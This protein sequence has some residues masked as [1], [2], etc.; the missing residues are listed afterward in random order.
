MA[1]F[2]SFGV[3]VQRAIAYHLLLDVLG[4]AV[5]RTTRLQYVI[6]LV[7]Q[8][9][10]RIERAVSTEFQAPARVFCEYR[11]HLALLFNEVVCPASKDGLLS[12]DH[13]SEGCCGGGCQSGASDSR[14]VNSKARSVSTSTTK[15]ATDLEV[16]VE[17]RHTA[18]LNSG[19]LLLIADATMWPS[20][21]Q[22]P[23]AHPC[24]VQEDLS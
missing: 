3:H 24:P 6:P 23:T 15:S 20:I 18:S 12:S 17:S 4:S 14:M 9:G 7:A 21:R 16:Y 19:G 22:P 8:S 11:P 5:L 1:F 10:S 2:D 13:L